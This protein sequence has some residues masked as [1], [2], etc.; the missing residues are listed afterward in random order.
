MITALLFQDVQYIVRDVRNGGQ[1][2][3]GYPLQVIGSIGSETHRH[4]QTLQLRR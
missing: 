1:M 4:K 2:S 3:M